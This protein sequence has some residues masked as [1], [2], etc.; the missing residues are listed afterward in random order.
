MT[1]ADLKEVLR[2]IPDHWSVCVET[3][4]GDDLAAAPLAGP[5][6]TRWE[7]AFVLIAEASERRQRLNLYDI[8]ARHQVIPVPGLQKTGLVSRVRRWLGGVYAGAV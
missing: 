1:V 3:V 8:R 5:S 2:D 7:H 4:E 6:D